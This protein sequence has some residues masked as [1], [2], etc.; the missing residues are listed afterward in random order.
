MIFAGNGG[1]HQL[2]ALDAN[3]GLRTLMVDTGT[4][5]VGDIDFFIPEPGHL[6]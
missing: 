6:H 1:Q 3:T 5:V 4:T 2:F